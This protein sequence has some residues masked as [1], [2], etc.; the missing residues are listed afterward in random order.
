MR[1]RWWFRKEC[2]G[3]LGEKRVRAAEG[4]QALTREKNSSRCLIKV[5]KSR[6]IFFFFGGGGQVINEIGSTVFLKLPG[7][8][9]SHSKNQV[10]L[11][12]KRK[13][14]G[15]ETEGKFST[16]ESGLSFFHRTWSQNSHETIFQFRVSKMWKIQSN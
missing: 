9:L 10:Y 8:F 16:S 13:G 14:G 1:D 5:K 15:T 3:G 4:P 6:E 7:H 2:C 12:Q 11:K